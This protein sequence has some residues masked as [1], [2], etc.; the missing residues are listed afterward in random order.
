MRFHGCYGNFCVRKNGQPT[1]HSEGVVLKA[2][3]LL[4]D[5]LLLL[6]TFGPSVNLLH[7]A[8]AA[9]LIFQASLLTIAVGVYWSGSF[10]HKIPLMLFLFLVVSF[11][12]IFI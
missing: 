2:F 4:K 1:R 5:L 10:S 9:G 12:S 6:L 11:F 7:Q 8:G 3:I